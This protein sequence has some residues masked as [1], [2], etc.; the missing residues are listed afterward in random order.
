MVYLHYIQQGSPSHLPEQLA[1]LAA[2]HAQHDVLEG[3]VHAA[4]QHGVLGRVAVAQ[5]HGE[6][7]Q[8]DQAPRHGRVEVQVRVDEDVHSLPVTSLRVART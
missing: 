2:H 1:T 7:V 6:G 3:A 4:V 8:G 5:Q